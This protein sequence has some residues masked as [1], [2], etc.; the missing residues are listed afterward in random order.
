LP[1][2]NYEALL[3]SE[4][5]ICNPAQ[6]GI[7]KHFTSDDSRENSIVNILCTI[8]GEIKTN[9]EDDCCNKITEKENVRTEKDLLVSSSALSPKHYISNNNIKNNHYKSSS[10]INNKGLSN[11]N[12]NLNLN[13]VNSVNSNNNN[14]L[15]LKSANGLITPKTFQNKFVIV[16]SAKDM[17]NSKFFFIYF[18]NFL[19]LF[20][21]HK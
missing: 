3:T 4:N 20:F 7:E 13:T 15:N 1:E 9:E 17:I 8:G 18:I 10:L 14:A 12:L 21:S 19:H 5:I 11:S 2:L 16:E 6:F